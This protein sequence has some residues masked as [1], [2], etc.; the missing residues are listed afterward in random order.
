ML[1][2]RWE[3][4]GDS[5][6]GPLRRCSLNHICTVETGLAAELV[7]IAVHLVE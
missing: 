4:T 2:K 7:S 6:Q 3:F 1:M 5:L